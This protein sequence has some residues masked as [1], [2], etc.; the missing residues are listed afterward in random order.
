MARVK[1]QIIGALQGS[2][3]DVVIKYRNG[4]PYAASRPATANTGT[5][6]VTIY[7]KNQGRFAGKLA[8]VIYDNKY[9]K[10][11]WTDY[12]DKKDLVY[13]TIFS[14]YY[15]SLNNDTLQGKVSLTPLYD[16]IPSN[17]AI[18]LFETGIKL[19]I[20]PITE[21]S[22]INADVEK[23]NNSGR[24]NYFKRTKQTLSR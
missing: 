9:F 18:E 12:S 6:Q 16:F 4:K 5:D 17:P 24:R 3:A 15:R 20:D 14:V 23:K 13:Q 2:I 8:K 19:T 11:V 10:K 21:Q 22:C 1:K 7:K